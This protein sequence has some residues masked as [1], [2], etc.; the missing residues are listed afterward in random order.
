MYVN[1][2]LHIASKTSDLGLGL[3]LAYVSVRVRI[4]IRPVLEPLK[5]F[6]AN[7]PS[8][9]KAY[10]RIGT[11]QTGLIPFHGHWVMERPW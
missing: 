10:G 9:I 11:G 6:G 4:R 2:S 3:V 1:I 8:G 5:T 7:R